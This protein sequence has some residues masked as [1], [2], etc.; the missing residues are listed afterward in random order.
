MYIF[1]AQH[2]DLAILGIDE[3]LWCMYMYACMHK[4]LVKCII[5]NLCMWIYSYI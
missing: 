1:Q 4:F 2:L 5:V 3:R